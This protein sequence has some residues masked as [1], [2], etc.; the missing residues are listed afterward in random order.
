M[1]QLNNKYGLNEKELFECNLDDKEENLNS[2][3]KGQYKKNKL[4][5]LKELGGNIRIKEEYNYINEI[6][7]IQNKKDDDNYENEKIT[8]FH[9]KKQMNLMKFKGKI[10]Q[11]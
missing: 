8:D 3:K 6:Q 10:Q 5:I 4:S 9:I 2:I 1:E 7:T 11:R